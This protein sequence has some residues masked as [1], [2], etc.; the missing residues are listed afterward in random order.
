MVD[1]DRF[2]GGRTLNFAHRGASA[3]APQNTLAAFLLAADMGA[4]GIELDVHLSADGEVVVIHDDTVNATTD[5]RGRVGEMTLSELQALDAGSWFDPGF[6]GE[7]IPTL[8]QVFDALGHRLLFN[9]E[10]KVEAGFHPLE[11]EAETVRLIEDSGMTDRVL[12]SSF[13]AS[14]LRRVREMN[15][16]IP[17]GLLYGT[18]KPVF[19]PRL[20]SWLSVPCDA[21]HPHF[22]MVGSRYVRSARRRGR[23]VNVW[24]V[25]TAHDM[26]RMQDLGVDGI[27]TN[28]PDVLRDVLAG[29]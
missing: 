11:Q 20:L 4:D 10:I 13:S 8:Q 15:P 25:N 1:L 17:L 12:L 23:R 5:G 22:R 9:I 21:V 3:H 27:I 28:Y 24:T 16:H 14:S 19:L 18:P 7:R 2:Y 26:R 29:G 6:Q